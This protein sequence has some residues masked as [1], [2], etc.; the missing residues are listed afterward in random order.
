M[1]LCHQEL[2]SSISK[3]GYLFRWSP[4]LIVSSSDSHPTTLALSRR[5]LHS[6]P[7]LEGHARVFCWWHFHSPWVSSTS[8]YMEAA[9]FPVCPFG[10]PTEVLKTAAPSLRH[11]RPTSDPPQFWLNAGS[12]PDVMRCRDL[13][14]GTRSLKTLALETYSYGPERKDSLNKPH[15]FAATQFP[16]FVSWLKPMPFF[17]FLA[18]WSLVPCCCPYSASPNAPHPHLPGT[19]YTNRVQLGENLSFPG[20]AESPKITGQDWTHRS[21]GYPPWGK[22]MTYLKNCGGDQHR[23]RGVQ[24]GKTQNQA[25]VF[26]VSRPLRRGD[27]GS[28]SSTWRMKRAPSETLKYIAWQR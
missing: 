5:P 9:M 4:R 7:S 16:F 8:R 20:A 22:R 11:L 3:V 17:F 1:L 23:K 15:P 13:E 26:K 10:V 6:P 2:Q 27:S 25:S 24:A 19:S 21:A 12:F 14:G 18:I 28:C